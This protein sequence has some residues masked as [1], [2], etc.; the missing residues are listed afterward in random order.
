MNHNDVAR[1]AVELERLQM[2][3]AQNIVTSEVRSNGFGTV[4]MGRL[5]RSIGQIADTYTFSNR[6]KAADVFDAQY[7]P[8]K[9]DRMMP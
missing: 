6:P 1:E 2:A 8:A 3:L 9:A 4:D 5:E 7:L